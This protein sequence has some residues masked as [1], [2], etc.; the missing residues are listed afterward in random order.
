[1]AG[2]FGRD[3]VLSQCLNDMPIHTHTYIT[4]APRRQPG[5]VSSSNDEQLLV[6]YYLRVTLR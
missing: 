3:R 1:M 4:P 6:I 2:D 5:S